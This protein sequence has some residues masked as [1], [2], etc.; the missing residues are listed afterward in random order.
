MSNCPYNFGV[1]REDYNL[2]ICHPRREL[3][4]DLMHGI[5]I[6]IKCVQE[7]GL[8]QTNRF[9]NLTD[10]SSVNLRYEE[11]SEICAEESRMR[12]AAQPIKACYLVP[13]T[14]LF[15]TIRMY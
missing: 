5:A 10:I 1:Y 6:S 13:N 11:V 3:T 12:K 4:S 8:L 14:L 2:L 7:P 15:G 9:H